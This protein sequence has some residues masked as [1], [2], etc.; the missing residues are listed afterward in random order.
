[1]KPRLSHGQRRVAFMPRLTGHK[2]SHV[3]DQ[4]AARA[5]AFDILEF[6]FGLAKAEIES[7]DNGADPEETLA[8]MKHLLEQ[9]SPK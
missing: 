2:R 6:F 1:M 8:A 5:T 4:H 9:N 3:G 7:P